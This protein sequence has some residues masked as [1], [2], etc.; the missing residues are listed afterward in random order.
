VEFTVAVLKLDRQRL[1]SRGDLE[2]G[3][4]VGKVG[5][6]DC[7]GDGTRYATASDPEENLL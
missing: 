3:L 6:V 4:E 1:L 2:P 5:Q 7:L